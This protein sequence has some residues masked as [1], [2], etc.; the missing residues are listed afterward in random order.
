VHAEI[1]SGAVGW[2]GGC[3]KGNAQK[4]VGEKRVLTTHS[5]HVPKGSVVSQ[6]T[7][8]RTASLLP[9]TGPRN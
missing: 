3:L 7:A 6:G 5:V 8:T 2:K 9:H 4:A 1:C